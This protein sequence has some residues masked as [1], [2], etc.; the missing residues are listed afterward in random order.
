MEKRRELP[1]GKIDVLPDR[2]LHRLGSTPANRLG[3]T[4]YAVEAI[5]HNTDEFELIRG[6]KGFNPYP[7]SPISATTPTGA[8]LSLENIRHDPIY[9]PRKR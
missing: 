9:W 3:V 1:G 2:A 8:T 6:G 5:V 4:D 7:A